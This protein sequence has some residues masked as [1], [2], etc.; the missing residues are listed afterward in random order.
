MVEDLI[1]GAPVGSEDSIIFGDL[2][3]RVILSMT[4]DF[5]VLT[6]LSVNVE[7]VIISQQESM[8]S[9]ILLFS[10]SCYK[11]LKQH[12]QSPHAALNKSCW[13]SFNSGGLSLFSVLLMQPQIPHKRFS[14]DSVRSRNVVSP[15]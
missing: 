14:G 5:A 9:D 4:D 7:N 11:A 6:E 13:Y 1:C 8:R 12:V 10:R 2:L 15:P 3:F